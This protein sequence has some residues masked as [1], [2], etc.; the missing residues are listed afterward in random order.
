MD[1]LFV[2]RN[3]LNIFHKMIL[4]QECYLV[5]PQVQHFV[6]FKNKKNYHYEAFGH[7]GD[8]SDALMTKNKWNRQANNEWTKSFFIWY[9]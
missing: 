9:E 1:L 3:I 7:Q 4:K 8:N 2:R 5:M 6:K